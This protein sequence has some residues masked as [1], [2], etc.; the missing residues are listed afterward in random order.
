MLSA[1]T[2]RPS[3]VSGV[4][5]TA[6][7][8]RPAAQAT[9]AGQRVSVAIASMWNPAPTV[10]AEKQGP[11]PSEYWSA[12]ISSMTPSVA[13]TV[14]RRPPTRNDTLAPS[15]VSTIAAATT[16]TSRNAAPSISSTTPAASI[17]PSADTRGA[18]G[19][20]PGRAGRSPFTMWVHPVSRKHLAVPGRPDQA[21]TAA[22]VALY[23]DSS[24]H[25]LVTPWRDECHLRHAG[26]VD[27]HISRPPGV[28]RQ[29]HGAVSGVAIQ[30]PGGG[31]HVLFVAGNAG[32]GQTRPGGPGTG[33]R[34][35]AF[36]G[37]RDS[38]CPAGP[39]L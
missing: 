36:H 31:L 15:A 24:D 1:P 22:W 33:H 7:I 10:A 5:M 9:K 2:A 38:W 30:H 12:S 37:L 14:A 27:R 13:A 29:A 11:S 3:T 32:V 20:I 34:A 19:G 25:G 28:T 16:T 35:L 18:P 26:A 23:G 21:A 8:P 17:L 4:E 6:L 39:S